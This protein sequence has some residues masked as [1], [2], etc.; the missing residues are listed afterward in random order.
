MSIFK[1]ILIIIIIVISGAFI[2]AK[3]FFDVNDYRDDITSYLSKK[4]GYEVTYKGTITLE[5]DPIAKITVTDILIKD[6]SKNSS[7]VAEMKELELRINK[8]EIIDGII[9]VEKIEIRDM[10]F[11]GINVDEILMKSYTL[12][13]DQKYKQYNR[14]NFTTIES[15]TAR[16]II[17]N[18]VMNVSSI[19]IDSSLLSIDGGGKINIRSKT[20]SF[21]MLGKLKE[22]KDVTNVYKDNYPIEL[23]DNNIPVKIVGPVDKI[24]F[25]V[26]LSEII[27]KQI[28]NPIKEKI[29][30]EIEEKILEQIK[31]PF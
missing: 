22:K 10:I 30:D 11:Y 31:L 28:I 27:T 14:Q 8:D 18:Q 21:N 13:K 23:Y 29:I 12:I 24:D 3:Y 17:D 9:D 26:D 19:N 15:M 6:P 20:L 25:K 7:T 1:K 2:Y 16:A 4:I 5:Y